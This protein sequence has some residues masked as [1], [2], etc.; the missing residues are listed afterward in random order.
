MSVR[1]ETYEDF[2][3]TIFNRLPEDVKREFSSDFKNDVEI[4][5]DQM[6]R[7]EYDRLSVVWAKEIDD[8][9]EQGYMV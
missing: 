2:K 8:L 5:F 4:V 9:R 7:E 6:V 3:K 1:I